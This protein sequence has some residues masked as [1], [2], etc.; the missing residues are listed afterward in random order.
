MVEREYAERLE[1]ALRAKERIN[2]NPERINSDPDN[3]PKI[4]QKSTPARHT[5]CS[6]NHPIPDKLLYELKTS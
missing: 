4:N 1:K 3:L 2:K 5:E 6:L